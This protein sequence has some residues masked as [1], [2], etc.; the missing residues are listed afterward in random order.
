MEAI[1]DAAESGHGLAWLPCWLIR[2]R[3]AAGH[4]VPLLEDVPAL[5]FRIHA[6]WLQTPHLPL[7]IRLAID[8]LASE[9]P[10]NAAP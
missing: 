7:R 3:V 1:A 10:D 9:L 2:D 6:L 8:A 4:L 5:V